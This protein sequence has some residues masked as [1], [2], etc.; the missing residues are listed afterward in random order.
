MCAFL[1]CLH[2]YHDGY[3]LSALRDGGYEW[4]N[5]GP[6][7]RVGALSPKSVPLR[8][9]LAEGISPTYEKTVVYWSISSLTRLGPFW[10]RNLASSIWGIS[11]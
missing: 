11:E 7:H 2:F 8:G 10:G 5:E 6:L 3:N 1:E 9:K 4:P